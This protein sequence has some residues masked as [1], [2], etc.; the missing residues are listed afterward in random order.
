MFPS[1]GARPLFR[2]EGR[3]L[4]E[5]VK[6]R[7][8]FFDFA[9][10]EGCQ[11][12]VVNL[13]E[14]LLDL[15]GQVEVVTWREA[16]SAAADD[17]DI[18]FVE[19]SI[20]RASDEARL[21]DIRAHAKVLVALGACAATGC[22]NNLVNF[23]PVDTARR[24]VYGKDAPQIEAYGA[25]TLSQV[26]PVD[27]SVYGCPIDRDDFLRIVKLLLQGRPV[28]HPTYPICVEC[29]LNGNQCR[30]EKGG[31]CLGP[32]ARAGCGAAC[33]SHNADCVACRG[34]VDDP[35]T[36]AQTE[37][38]QKYGLALDDVLKR[39]R[40]FLGATEVAK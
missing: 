40:L 37:V 2:L 28:Q 9:C 3:R 29:K 18:A 11:L 32:I 6:P 39:Y 19:G 22:V 17:C 16:S 8:A 33:P 4:E 35:N 34:L 20:V 25:R 14:R 10:C 36:Q 5:H 30:F 12:Q 7:I 13:E 27:A 24:E 21:K 1:L 15:L 26:V 31:F 38:L 23:R